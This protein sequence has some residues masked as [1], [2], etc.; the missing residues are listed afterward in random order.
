MIGK[1]NKLKVFVAGIPKELN[2][3]LANVTN[4]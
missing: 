2:P 4:D 3:K 1:P